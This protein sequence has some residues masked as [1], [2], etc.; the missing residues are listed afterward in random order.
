L[1]AAIKATIS[2][3][4]HAINAI[5]LFKDGKVNKIYFKGKQPKV[6]FQTDSY[7]FRYSTF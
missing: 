3:K 7:I 5:I 6:N 2:K 4:L 1:T